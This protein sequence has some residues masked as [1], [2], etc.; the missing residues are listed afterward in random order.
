MVG[1]DVLLQSLLYFFG[2]KSICREMGTHA[3]KSI[4]TSAEFS[5]ELWPVIWANSFDFPSLLPEGLSRLRDR[6]MYM[7]SNYSLAAPC[8]MLCAGTPALLSQECPHY[9]SFE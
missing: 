6:I 2:I 8:Q 3:S 4:A 7:T 1:E 5:I 9:K